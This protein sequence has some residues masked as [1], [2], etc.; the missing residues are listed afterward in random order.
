MK[1]PKKTLSLEIFESILDEFW[2]Y[3]K[4]SNWPKTIGV[5][6]LNHLAHL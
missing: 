1:G 5:K 2:A 6:P 4:A 3:F